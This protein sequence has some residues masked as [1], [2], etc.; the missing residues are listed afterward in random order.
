MAQSWLSARYASLRW[1][2]YEADAGDRRKPLLDGRGL[3]PVDD[4]C[5]STGLDRSSVEA[6]VVEGKLEGAMHP[7]GRV[8]D[9]DK[10]YFHEADADESHD[11]ER[12]LARPDWS[13][14]SEDF[15]D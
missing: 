4:S 2:T 6:L 12:Y 11:A 7:D 5:R 14:S 9:P 8:A 1:R 3:L 10:L 15:R 13:M